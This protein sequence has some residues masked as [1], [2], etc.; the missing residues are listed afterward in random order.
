MPQLALEQAQ[1]LMAL[2]VRSRQVERLVALLELQ[3]SEQSAAL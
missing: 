1:L 3:L 2:Q